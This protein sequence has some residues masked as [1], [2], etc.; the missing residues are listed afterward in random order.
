MGTFLP[1]GPLLLG[2]AHT[3][4]DSPGGSM[5]RALPLP[6]HCSAHC[7]K[8]GRHR[9]NCYP[10]MPIAIGKVWTYRLLFVFCLF[11]RL[12]IF[13]AR[14]KLAASNFGRRF[15]DGLGKESPILGN[16]APQKPK[17]GRIGAR[18]GT[19][20]ACVDNRQSTSLTVLFIRVTVTAA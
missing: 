17:I 2:A 14:K 5:R 19:P 16:F 13:P 8:E 12:R 10:H 15:R 6:Q 7:N 4:H 9:P 11:V 18:R 1:L 3:Q 20:W